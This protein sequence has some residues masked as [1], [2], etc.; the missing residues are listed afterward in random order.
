M[1]PESFLIHKTKI[2]GYENTWS[3]ESASS[4]KKTSTNILFYNL[5]AANFMKLENSRNKTQRTEMQKND[6]K[7]HGKGKHLW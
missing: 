6:K 1:L 4:N 7:F 2:K 3:K 5:P